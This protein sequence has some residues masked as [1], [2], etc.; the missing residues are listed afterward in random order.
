MAITREGGCEWIVSDGAYV[1]AGYHDPSQQRLELRRYSI[2]DSGFQVLTSELG[3]REDSAQPVFI[4]GGFLYGATNPST[5]FGTSGTFGTKGIVRVSLATG[6]SEPVVTMEGERVILAHAHDA[7]DANGLYLA[8]ADCKC[9][10]YV[11]PNKG[12][13]MSCALFDCTQRIERVSLSRR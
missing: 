3:V 9:T 7:R 4:D 5:S 8:T 12:G 10:S 13:G 11:G 2:A 6:A 1:Y